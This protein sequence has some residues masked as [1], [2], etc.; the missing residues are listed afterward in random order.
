MYEPLLEVLV[1]GLPILAY[2]VGAVALTTIGFLTERTGL[3][4]LLSGDLT[5]GI[6]MTVVGAVFLYAGI[7]LLGYREVLTRV[8][9]SSQMD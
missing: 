2:A 9:G 4:H 3:E 7:V 5:L 1:E 6:W 8:G